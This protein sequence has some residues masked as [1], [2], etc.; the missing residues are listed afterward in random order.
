MQIC[1]YADMQIC[2]RVDIGI[3]I[4]ID[5]DIDICI[6]MMQFTFLC[7]FFRAFFNLNSLNCL[8]VLSI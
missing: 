3:G 6:S 1:R 8:Y 7:T 5:V 2:R 4:G